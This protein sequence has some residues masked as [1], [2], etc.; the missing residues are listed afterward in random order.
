MKL[1][2]AWRELKALEDL[3]VAMGSSWAGRTILHL[4]DSS[5]VEKIMLKGSARPYLQKLALAIY[6]ACKKYGIVLQVQWKSRNDPRLQLADEFSRPD[7]DLDDWGI[8]QI[9]F[10][11][12]QTRMGKCDVDL[13]ATDANARLPK[14]FSSLPSLHAEGVNA[15]AADWSAFQLG[16]ACPPPKLVKAVIRQSVAQEASVMLV[17]PRWRSLS[18]WSMIAEDRFHFNELIAGYIEFW[19]ILHKGEHVTSTVFSG[20]TPFPFLALLLHPKG[21]EFPF[22]ARVTPCF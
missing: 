19:P 2:S 21:L 22:R 7:F 1:S 18:A 10:E 15:F 5:S 4:T 9:S 16:F 13:F 6:K 17:I 8:D 20:K 3:Y 11:F 14:Y 12:L